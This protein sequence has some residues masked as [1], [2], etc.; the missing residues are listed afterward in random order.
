MFF[1]ISGSN[2]AAYLYYN[3]QSTPTNVINCTFFHDLGSVDSNYSGKCNFTNIATNVT[4]NGTNT[5]VVTESFGDASTSLSDLINASK[6]N[7]NFVSNQVGVYYG[8]NA[9]E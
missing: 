1:R 2:T 9:W 5:N 4:T 7:E 3:D 8:E 6:V